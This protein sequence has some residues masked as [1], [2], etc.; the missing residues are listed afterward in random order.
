MFQRVVSIAA[1]VLLMAVAAAA[2]NSTVHLRDGQLVMGTYLGGTKDQVQLLVNGQVKIIDT[3]D[4]ASIDFLAPEA[5]SAISNDSSG[6]TEMVTVPQGA[7]ILVRMID[8]VDSSVNQPGD[9]FHASLEDDLQIGDVLV[10]QKGADVYG[11]LV[12]VQSAGRV[13]GKSELE[14]QLTGIRTVAGTIQSIVT[15]DYQQAGKSRTK[16]TVEHSVLGAA[17]GAV[18]GGVAGGG[19]GAAKGAG[20]GAAA[21][22]GVTVITRGQ[23][24]KIP[25][26]TLLQFQLAQPLTI[27][28]PKASS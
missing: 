26:E 10:A 15:G 18:I 8:S 21:G 14:L 12:S 17:L 3:S 7:P 2:Q 1:M 6:L 4:I 25:S 19:G 9:V 28:L 27:T 22:T 5:A 16:Q 20:V 11:K 23:Q 24:V 13:T